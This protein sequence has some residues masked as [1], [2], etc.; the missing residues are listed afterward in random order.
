[1]VSPAEAVALMPDDLPAKE[2]GPLLCAGITVFNSLRHSGARAGDIVAVQGIG[3]LGHLAVQYAARMGFHTVAIARGQD[4]EPLAIKLGAKRY[5]DSK[6]GD[7]S[8]QLRKTGGAQVILAT[9]PDAKSISALVGGLAP[10]GKLLV[11]AAALEPL[12][13]NALDLISGRR[14]I[15]GWPSG[16]AKDSED[17]LRFSALVGVRPMI[18]AFPLAKVAEAYE[19]MVSG[20]VRFRAVLTMS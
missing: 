19:R 11:V 7:A 10:Q 6:A 9:A 5:I 13:I 4:K 20:K 17:T 12:S 16:T 15:Q 18:E 2:A 8:E 3:G 1:M 14:S